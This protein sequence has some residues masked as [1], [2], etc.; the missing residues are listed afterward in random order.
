MAERNHIHKLKRHKY[1]NGTA[2]FFCVN[3]CNFKVEAALAVG[4]KVLCYYCDTPFIMSERD[5]VVV[6]PHCKNCS[7]RKIKDSD[8]N[9]RYVRQS[10]DVFNKMAED[11]VNSLKE[12]LQHATTVIE[13][14]ADEI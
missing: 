6:R 11:S 3:D 4:K 5:T 12:R 7:K 10:R 14:D 8:G 2:V 1:A 9:V 13:P